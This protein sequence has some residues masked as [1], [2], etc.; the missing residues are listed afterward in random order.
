MSSTRT[1]EFKDEKSSKFWE[2]TQSGNSVTVRYGKT[3]TNGQSQ[4]KVFTDA[5]TASKHVE[6]LIQEKTTKGYMEKGGGS[7]ASSETVVIQEP[8]PRPEK[9]TTRKATKPTVD[10]PSKPKNPAQDPD[11][12]RESLLALLDKGETTN[13]LLAKHPR[14]SAELLEKLSHS[15]DKAT[16][17]GVAANPNTP[18]EIYVKLGQQ[19]PKEFLANPALD[20]LLMM[21]PALMEEVPE[22]LLVRLL[23]Q[24]ACPA[25][26][27]SW[28]ADRPQERVQ[29]AVAM[30]PKVPEQGLEKLRLSPHQSVREA[31]KAPT[32]LDISDPIED[33][34][35]A[36]EQAVKDRL[37]SMTPSELHE[38]WS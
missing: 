11:A 9:P 10:K 17:Q 16:R 7:H 8:S 27:L 30:N 33:P 19:F 37:N 15:S 29:L 18:P 21:N 6:R 24:A 2:I 25:S 31:V 3:G 4:D 34:E 22:A 13:R 35:K 20:L 23:K 14:A 32:G 38:S 36:F 12:T 26:L 5:S 1:F 28:A